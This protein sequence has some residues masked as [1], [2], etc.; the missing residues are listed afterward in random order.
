[1]SKYTHSRAKDF[2]RQN[3]VET[4]TDLTAFAKR[5][6]IAC[7][8]ILNLEKPLNAGRAFAAD[9]SDERCS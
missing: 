7:K 2:A 6:V 4:L 5:I 9:D 3:V 1:M 8:Y